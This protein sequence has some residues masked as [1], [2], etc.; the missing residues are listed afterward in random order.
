MMEDVQQ[1]KRIENVPKLSTPSRRAVVLLTFVAVY[2]P[3]SWLLFVKD[4]WQYRL[5]WIK[6]WPE[7]PGVVLMFFAQ[8]LTGMRNHFN[9]GAVTMHLVCSHATICFLGLALLLALRF[10]QHAW[11][12]LAGVAVVSMVLGAMAYGLFAA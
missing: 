4:Q 7:L 8:A 11:K 10:R 2:F 1:T 5:T 12:I 6:M 9:I 3:Y